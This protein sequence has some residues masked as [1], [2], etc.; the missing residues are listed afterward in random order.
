MSF[1]IDLYGDHTEHIQ[2]P[3]TIALKTSFSQNQI[4]SASGK[5]NLFSSIKLQMQALLANIH[6]TEPA[7]HLDTLKIYEQL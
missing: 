2:N 4:G 6:D 1:F 3:K 5:D 7:F